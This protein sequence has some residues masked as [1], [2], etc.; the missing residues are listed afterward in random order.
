MTTC[1]PRAT[2]TSQAWRS[3]SASSSAAMIPSVSGGQ[4]ERQHDEVGAR[5]G[6]GVAVGLEHV[7]D[8]VHVG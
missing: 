5:Q 4:G 2:L 3:I 6:V 8:A 7:V 1:R